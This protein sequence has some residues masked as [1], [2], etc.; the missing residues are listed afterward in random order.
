ML[1]HRNGRSLV[2]CSLHFT[3]CGR[4]LWPWCMAL[5]PNPRVK[6]G[7]VL[8][9][10]TNFS[11]TEMREGN[12]LQHIEKAIDKMKLYHA[13][14][15]KAYDPNKG[16]DNERWLRVFTRT[17]SIHDFLAGSNK[18]L[19]ETFKDQSG[20]EFQ[21]FARVGNSP[22]ILLCICPSHLKTKPDSHPLVTWSFFVP[23]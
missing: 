22:T 11:T 1:G 6:I 4:R 20:E 15:I 17:S 2:D 10:M 9:L 14:H 5:I 3:L 18:Y 23:S 19:N 8:V 21:A 12:G 13:E 7:M 16:K